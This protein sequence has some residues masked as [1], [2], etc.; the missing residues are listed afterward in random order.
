MSASR[1]SDTGRPLSPVTL[2]LIVREAGLG[3][4]ADQRPVLASTGLAGAPGLR[5]A[6][7]PLRPAAVS[8]ADP[9]RAESG[10]RRD[11][12]RRMERS[13]AV[14]RLMPTLGPCLETDIRNAIR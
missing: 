2:M 6:Q 7:R 14:E 8:E 4:A 3:L 1:A 13:A 11:G 12:V 10:P 9:R 5:P